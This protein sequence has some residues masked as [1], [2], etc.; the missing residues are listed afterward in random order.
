MIARRTGGDVYYISDLDDLGRIYDQ[1]VSELR[2][3]YFLAFNTGHTL[4]PEELEEIEIEVVPSGIEVRTLLAS[5]QRG[6]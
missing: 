5:Q 6:G 1:I 3:Q 2:R 4:T